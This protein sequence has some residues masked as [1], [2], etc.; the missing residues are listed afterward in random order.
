MNVEGLDNIT[1]YD[2]IELVSIL[3]IAT[4]ITRKKRNT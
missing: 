1:S 2:D 3:G 4:V